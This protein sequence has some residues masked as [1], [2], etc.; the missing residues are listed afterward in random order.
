M[1]FQ[2]KHFCKW[3]LT[4]FPDGHAA[5]QHLQRVGAGRRSDQSGLEHAADHLRLLQAL[6]WV[7]ATAPEAGVRDGR[8]RT[9]GREAGRVDRAPPRALSKKTAL[10]EPPLP[11]VSERG[12]IYPGPRAGL[13]ARA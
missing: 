13:G 6:A 10:R 1:I 12:L 3:N 9:A 11:P 2:P 5:C 4:D 7:L 8:G